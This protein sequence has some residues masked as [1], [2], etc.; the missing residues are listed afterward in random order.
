MASGLLNLL[1]V[2]ILR[3][4]L[5]ITITQHGVSFACT[6]L[7]IHEDSTVNAIESTKYNLLT[8]LLIHFF[9]LFILAEAPILTRLLKCY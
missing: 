9:I 5:L 7:P 4:E 2:Y 8:R 6:S 1:Q 3:L